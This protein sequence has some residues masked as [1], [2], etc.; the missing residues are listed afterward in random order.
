MDPDSFHE[1]LNEMELKTFTDRDRFQVQ[2]GFFFE[3]D[4]YLLNKISAPDMLLV[5]RRFFLFTIM[6]RFN[7]LTEKHIY[8]SLKKN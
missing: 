8:N 4:Q 3:Y 2:P 1:M 7:E 5:Y 6:C